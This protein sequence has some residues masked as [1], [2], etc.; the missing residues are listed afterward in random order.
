MNV[1]FVMFC[2]KSFSCL[3]RHVAKL[4]LKQSLMQYH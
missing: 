1:V 4:M 2:V 3:I